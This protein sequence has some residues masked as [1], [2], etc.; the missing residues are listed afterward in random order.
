MLLERHFVLPAQTAVIHYPSPTQWLS[1]Q[2][3]TAVSKLSYDLRSYDSAPDWMQLPALVPDATHLGRFATP[4]PLKLASLR[5]QA[6]PIASAETVGHTLIGQLNHLPQ[7]SW[8]APRYWMHPKGWLYAEFSAE[9]LAQWLQTVLTLKPCLEVQSLVQPSSK[10]RI[11]I[12][13]GISTDPDLFELQYAHARCCSLLRL[14]HQAQLIQLVDTQSF[15]LTSPNP[16]PWLALLSDSPLRTQSKRQLL[17]ALLNFPQSLGA[18]TT[19]GRLHRTELEDKSGY[20]TLVQWPFSDRTLQRHRLWSQ[21]FQQFYR[22]CRVLDAMHPKTP[23]L[24][25]AQLASLAILKNVLE[26]WLITLL[27]VDAPTEL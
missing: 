14:G 13:K 18:G 3:A 22:D 11:A 20:Q 16:V 1:D 5:S 15:S 21:M 4:L 2:L 17:L 25:Q 6:H 12:S 23:E 8:I 7:A 10:T 24:A 19:Y 26:F 9:S 27:R